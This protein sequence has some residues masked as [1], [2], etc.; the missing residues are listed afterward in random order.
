MIPPGLREYLKNSYRSLRTYFI[1]GLLV[2]IPVYVTVGLVRWMYQRID[3]PMN[4]WISGHLEVL[5]RNFPS[6]ADWITHTD[7]MGNKVVH[8]PG[9]GVVITVVVILGVGLFAR[10]YFGNRIINLF[11]RLVFRIPLVNKIYNG[12][13]QVSAAFLERNK[14]LF[15]AVVL[16]EYPRR[17][18]YQIGFLTQTDSGEVTEKLGRDM[19]C[20]FISTTPNPTSGMLIIVPRSD[21]TVLDMTVEEGIKMVISGGVVTPEKAKELPQASLPFGLPSDPENPTPGGNP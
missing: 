21:L 11:E 10:N 16:V 3:G 9:L 14:N 17:G 8:V 15:Q 2:L 7:R 6:F 13:K 5:V 19:T 4:D 12:V 1:T 18:I 20:V